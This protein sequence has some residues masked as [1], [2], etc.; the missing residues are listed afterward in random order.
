MI[1]YLMTNCNE[2]ENHNE[3]PRHRHGHKCTKYSMS[4]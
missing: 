4:R 1:H 3:R 2:N